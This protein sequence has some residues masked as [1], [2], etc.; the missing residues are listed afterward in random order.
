LPTF[1][2]S[3][4]RNGRHR[5][6]LRNPVELLEYVT[7]LRRRWRIVAAITGLGVALGLLLP[8]QGSATA[9]SAWHATSVMAPP[10]EAA[11]PVGDV[12]LLAQTDAVLQG[13]ATELGVTED[14]RSLGALVS[15]T[16]TETGLVNVTAVGSSPE[17]AQ[18][19]ANAFANNLASQAVAQVE[20]QASA[21]AARLVT[22]VS[23]LT[24]ALDAAE[25]E[26]NAN[27]GDAVLAA[28]RD[29][30]KA[31]LGIVTERLGTV[32]T[33]TV[34]APLSVLQ[35]AVAMP[36]QDASA[37]S[38]PS[39]PI[40]RI[41]LFGGLGLLLGVVAALVVE[42]VDPRLLTPS[43]LA[44]GYRMPVLVST[45]PIPDQPSNGI[46]YVAREPESPAA[47]ALRA[48]RMSL[49]LATP[50][51]PG[52]ASA[53]ASDP[54][55]QQ[56]TYPGPAPTRAP[57]LDRSRV[58]LVTAGRSGVGVTTT[59]ANLAAVF[60]TS[61]MSVLAIDVDQRSAS[62]SGLFGL[63]NRRGV[64]DLLA[65]PTVV[66]SDLRALA[67]PVAGLP[68]L[69]VLPSGVSRAFR[70]ADPA[71]VEELLAAARETAQI[72]LVDSAALLEGV[73]ALEFAPFIDGVVIVARP[74]AVTRERAGGVADALAQLR[75]PAFGLVAAGARGARAPRSTAKAQ[76]NEPAP[77]ASPP[78][79]ERILS[80]ELFRGRAR[81][82]GRA[83][84]GSR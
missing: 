59:V 81:H 13:V 33:A 16:P 35:P 73:E 74:G 30:L 77:P 5:W 23:A 47:D 76:V 45:P 67:A 44:R 25:A 84:V 10:S 51:V 69:R 11:S 29:A 9:V 58:V 79:E 18:A 53:H 71:R 75:I 50:R 56:S 17:Q 27:P 70:G 49:L 42:R 31:S 21:E 24:A 46:P 80:P 28:R 4:R 32:Q 65:Q 3:V 7:I 63:R 19:L 38:V 14:P 12:S 83:A 57:A 22:Q 62:L 66:A 52:S 64:S 48:L 36:E 61:G 15:V 2:L 60:A 40:T 78:A 26:A 8:S 34:V 72:V 55:G 41:I 20:Q 1:V 37:L 43:E 54:V 68:E 39:D 82:A 6:N